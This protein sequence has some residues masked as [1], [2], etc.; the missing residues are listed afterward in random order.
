MRSSEVWSTT[1]AQSTRVVAGQ[2]AGHVLRR[3]THVE[4]DLRALGCRPGGRRARPPPARSQLRVRADG[5]SKTS[6]TPRPASEPVSASG[7]DVP[8]GESTALELA[9]PTGR[10]R[11]GSAVVPAH[12]RRPT[13]AE[14]VGEHGNGLVD[15]VVGHQQR[16]GQPD[17]VGPWR[18]DHQTRLEGGGHRRGRA[19]VLDGGRQQQ[20]RPRTAST[21]GSPATRRPAARRPPGRGRAR[22][23]PPSWPGS[24]GPRRRP[25][26]GRRTSWRGPR[27][28]RRRP[29]RRG[30]SRPR[31]G[32]RCPS[33]LAMVTTSG[34]MPSVLEAEPAPGAAEP[35]LDLVDHEQDAPFGAQL[36]HRAEVVRGGHDHPGLALDG[37]DQHRADAAGS[38]ALSS[39]VDVVVGDVVEPF[40]QRARNA[41]LGR[42][43]G[44]VQRRQ[45]AAV[46]PIPGADDD[47]APG[48]AH[49]APASRR[50]RWPPRPS[51]RRTPAPRHARSR[52]R[53][54]GRWSRA[55]SGAT[56][57]AE[58]VGDVQQ[59][60]GLR[61]QRV[62]DRRVGVAERG[63]GQPREEVEV[64]AALACPTASC[65]R[66]A[67]R[68]PAV[69]DRCA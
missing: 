18:V 30:P 7:P 57:V 43:A 13:A 37:L 20:A 66:P 47:V 9:G 10:R 11:R 1:R 52:R 67:R 23:R 53:S 41:V 65:P 46:E 40:G 42:L 54:A 21:P 29:P 48:P 33:A 26:A 62:G 4:P 61:G 55:T 38:Q 14:A 63:H 19:A 31:W 58:Q 69:P 3:L 15:L 56:H 32:R 45:R 51:W 39:A 28:R 27:A 8:P 17:R 2:G 60:A 36:A 5:F 64:P 25:A 34:S 24:P 49:A 16:R 22:P 50:T 6:A 12:R 68:S 44:G 35:G 59:R